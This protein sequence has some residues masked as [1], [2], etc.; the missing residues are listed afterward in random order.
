MTQKLS[1]DILSLP[2]Q[3]QLSQDYETNQELLLRLKKALFKAMEEELTPKQQQ[4]IKLYYFQNKNTV[5]IA[6]IFHNNKSTISRIRRA[7]VHKLKTCLQYS[8][9]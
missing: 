1:Y 3:F 8:M 9:M 5:Q 6:R 7:A 2:E 4:V